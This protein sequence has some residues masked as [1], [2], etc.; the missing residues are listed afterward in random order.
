MYLFKISKQRIVPE[1]CIALVN[2]L[3]DYVKTLTSAEEWVTFA[4]EYRSKWQFDQCLGALDGR[5]IELQSPVHSGTNFFNYKEYCSIVYMGL[6]DT[7]YSFL[8]FDMGCQARIS[9]EG[10]FKNCELWKKLE[11]NNPG[12]PANKALP[13]TVFA[14]LY[15]IVLPLMC[16]CFTTI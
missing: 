10:V 14:V 9:D 8:Y 7:N 2:A 16:S 4:D 6:V 15:V 12:L 13:D 1:V 11:Q 3:C 5:H